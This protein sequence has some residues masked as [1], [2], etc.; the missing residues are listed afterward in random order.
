MHT[1]S[2]KVPNPEMESAYTTQSLF[3]SC[4]DGFWMLFQFGS[5]SFALIIFG[6]LIF[7]SAAALVCVAGK[8]AL[9]LLTR[10]RGD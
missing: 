1:I 3:D 7:L 2:I 10:S 8:W 5:G 4:R 6:L 9:I